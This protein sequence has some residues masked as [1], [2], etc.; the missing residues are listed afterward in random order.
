MYDTWVISPNVEELV[1]LFACALKRDIDI[2]IC[3]IALLVNKE[4]SCKD[5]V[6]ILNRQ[7]E[8]NVQRENK[9]RGRP[10]GSISKSKF[11]IYRNGIVAMLKEG[12]SVSKIAK[13]LEVSR[14]SLKDYIISRKLKES[15]DI[16]KSIVDVDF[17]PKKEDMLSSA[18]NRVKNLN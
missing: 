13:T 3:K 9:S 16:E 2:Y 12:M 1:D 10:K 8:L 14:T 7:R 11:D 15:I 5:I 18:C 4:T 6:G 17:N